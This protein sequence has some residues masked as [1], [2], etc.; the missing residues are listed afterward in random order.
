MVASHESVT[1]KSVVSTL[2]A[3]I[4]KSFGDGPPHVRTLAEPR[5]VQALILHHVKNHHQDLVTQAALK[6]TIR[7]I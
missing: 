4:V 3:R 5:C 2:P 7:L 6:Q 1:L